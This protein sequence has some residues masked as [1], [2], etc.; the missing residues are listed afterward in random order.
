MRISVNPIVPEAM[1]VTPTVP[2]KCKRFF[3]K[4]LYTSDFFSANR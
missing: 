1:I 2:W 4:A 3:Y